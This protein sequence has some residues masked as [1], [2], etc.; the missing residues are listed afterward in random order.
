MTSVAANW[1]EN[2]GLLLDSTPTN[3]DGVVLITSAALTT[4][5]NA[6]DQTNTY[7]RG[8][9]VFVTT[10]SFGSGASTIVVTIE[11]KDSVSGNYYTILASASL[12]ASTF[13]TLTI[14]P[15][16]VAASN[17]IANALLPKTWRVKA[18]ASAWGTGG[19]TVG[20]SCALNR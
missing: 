5:T 14:Y 18:T 15:G 6:S 2:I 3:T 13:T 11:G 1:Q 9:V 7:Y 16:A 10:G 4:N 8:V 19:S 17:S 20:V 12:T